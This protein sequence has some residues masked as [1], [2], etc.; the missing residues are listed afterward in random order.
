MGSNII[1]KE[2]PINDL[3]SMSRD[4]CKGLLKF[5]RFVVR[6][7]RIQ[8]VSRDRFALISTFWYRFI[9]HCITC[10]KPDANITVDEQLLPTKSMCPITQYMASKPNKFGIKFWSAVDAESHYLVN[11]FPYLGKE[12]KRPKSQSL[13]EYVVTKLAEPFLNERRN[14]TCD[15]FFTSV[16]LPISL[17]IKKTTIVGIVNKIQREVPKARIFKNEG[18]TLT[19]YQGKPSKIFPVLSSVQKA[20]SISDTPK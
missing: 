2:Q 7:S 4:R 20:V 1:A 9:S 17:E 5:I 8:Q 11:G 3:W 6:S 15:N 12:T 10:Y 14:T 19:G 16:K 18:L 13:T